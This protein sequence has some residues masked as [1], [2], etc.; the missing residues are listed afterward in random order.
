MHTS[1]TTSDLRAYLVNRLA[2]LQER[3]DTNPCGNPCDM[4]RYWDDSARRAELKRLAVAF[5]V[6]LP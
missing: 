6:R 2:E 4:A 1:L 3:L 5:R